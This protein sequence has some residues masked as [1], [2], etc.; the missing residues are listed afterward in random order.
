MKQAGEKF[1]RP[2]YQRSDN[3]PMIADIP[4]GEVKGVAYLEWLRRTQHHSWLGDPPEDGKGGYV[5]DY[6]T[7]TIGRI[8]KGRKEYVDGLKGHV[9]ERVRRWQ[10][11]R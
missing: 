9:E 6:L 5:E 8:R 3:L 4:G 1:M 7:A 10:R 2:L 11:Q